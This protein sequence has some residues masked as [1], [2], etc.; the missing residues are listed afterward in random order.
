MYIYVYIC[1]YKFRLAPLFLS[2]RFKVGWCPLLAGNT[3]GCRWV[4][5]ILSHEKMRPD[6]H[7]Y[8]L[9]PAHVA[10][11]SGHFKCHDS[12]CGH[13]RAGPLICDSAS[14]DGTYNPAGMVSIHIC[15]YIYL[16][17]Y[18]IYVCMYRAPWCATRSRAT[19]PTT[20]RAW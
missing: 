19:E 14:C 8:H 10:D 17:I 4:H 20:R 18:Y 6:V 16:Y 9:G 5:A 7:C 15:I 11:P 3:L 12:E 13:D 2:R 1:I